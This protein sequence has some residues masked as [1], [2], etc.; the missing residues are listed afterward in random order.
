[1]RF[2]QL[3]L[4]DDKWGNLV[5]LLLLLS[6]LSIMATGIISYYRIQ[7]S[8]SGLRKRINEDFE[9][10][11][12]K[13]IRM[14]YGGIDNMLEMYLITHNRFY[15]EQLDSAAKNTRSLI[16]DLKT[17]EKLSDTSI[18]MVDSLRH[19]V[20]LKVR[21]VSQIIRFQQDA[22]IEKL[23]EDYMN[24]QS[25]R[26]AMDRAANEYVPGK[27]KNFWNKIGLKKEKEKTPEPEV[28]EESEVSIEK[29]DLVQMAQAGNINPYLEK[30]HEINVWFAHT[31]RTLESGELDRLDLERRET[32]RSIRS[33]NDSIMLLGAC[34][35]LFI[36]LA[37]MVY[38]RYIKK[39]A[40]IRKR[41]SVSK[42]IA[43]EMAMIKERFMA[44]MSHEIRT[45]LN[46]ISGF[47]DQ[48]SASELDP[49]QQKQTSI[50]Q[51]SIQHILNIINDI[52]DFSKL[53]AG[54]LELQKKG[55]ELEKNVRQTI[56]LLE[57]LIDGKS[58]QLKLHLQENMPPV[59]IGDAYR[60]RQILLN[61]IGNAIKYTQVGR[62]DVEIGGEITGEK[63]YS[64]N[65]CVKDTGIGID[66]DEIK[67]IFKEFHMADNARWSKAG[68]SGLGLSI[69]K[70]LIELFKGSISL[71]S[72]IHE[73]TTVCIKLPL[74]IGQN[75]DVVHENSYLQDLFFLENKKI[76][77]ADDEPFNRQLLINILHKYNAKIF[78]A[79]NGHHV[80]S[81]LDKENIDCILMDIK[82]PEMN[83]L[84]TTG[85][86]RASKQAGIAG[87]PIVAVSAAMS[88]DNLTNFRH[89]DVE[90]FLEKPFKESELLNIL[91]KIF[92]PGGGTPARAS[93][94]DD[95]INPEKPGSLFDLEDLQKQTGNDPAF[96]QDMIDTLIK[97]TKLGINE[98]SDAIARNNRPNINL[99]AHRLASPLRYI[100]ATEAYKSIKQ[101]EYLTESGDEIPGDILHSQL[102]SFIE[103]FENLEKELHNFMKNTPVL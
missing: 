82:M 72:K 100:K 32:Q 92:R 45:P 31:V 40:T 70:M 73:G 48:L 20:N 17:S 41:L 2:R 30:D 86:I 52:L 21:N 50:I 34:T 42:D 44:N 22:S 95:F 25:I 33:A 15:L 77:V 93:E 53:N 51:K 71:Q 101:M 102:Q 84:Q 97:S 4:S 56:E 11:K 3:F 37:A 47:V 67:N 10:S 85:K 87:I 76:I 36:L 14:E 65:I 63:S 24:M 18:K 29:Q 88:P 55:F 89:F 103:K 90:Y 74:E 19:Y 12:I 98:L 7:D 46:A 16:S 13:G 38:F 66:Q 83:G 78:E 6:F 59:L 79:E 1:M 96:L 28:K 61:I 8:V 27:K 23:I 57:T 94:D 9:I 64:L 60:L 49:K 26:S 68:S 81:I 43:E 35:A 39:L 5:Y 80:L 75:S 91:Y 62:I 54:R 99:I 58:V 69:T